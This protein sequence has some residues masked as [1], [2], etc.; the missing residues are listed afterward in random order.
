ML[1]AALPPQFCGIPH[2]TKNPES[3][4]KSP[5]CGCKGVTL[6]NFS[7]PCTIQGFF[8]VLIVEPGSAPLR[9]VSAWGHAHRHSPWRR[10]FQCAHSVC[11]WRRSFVRLPDGGHQPGERGHGFSGCGAVPSPVHGRGSLG[12][13]SIASTGLQLFA[14]VTLPVMLGVLTHQFA[15]PAA[16]RLR[17]R[18]HTLSMVRC[19]S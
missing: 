13:F 14:I 10:H 8:V 11:G 2:R 9:P 3:R 6:H 15:K 16:R 7:F 12:D 18:T 1:P 19:L 5:G 4:K 17:L